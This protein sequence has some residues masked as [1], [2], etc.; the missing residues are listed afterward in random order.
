[1]ICEKLTVE[2]LVCKRGAHPVRAP[3]ITFSVPFFNSF[4]DFLADH[5]SH[6]LVGV[7]MK[8]QHGDVDLL[9]SWESPFRENA[10]IQSTA[11][12]ATQQ[13]ACSQN[14]SMTPW[15]AFAFGTRL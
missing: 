12:D 10:L 1:M 13:C 5:R 15:D 2:F 14:D 4:A 6:N 8:Y 9:K 7:A 3:G 11:L